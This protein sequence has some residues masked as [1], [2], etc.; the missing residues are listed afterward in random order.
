MVSSIASIEGPFALVLDSI[1]ALLPH[2]PVAE[3]KMALSDS[4]LTVRPLY[5]I[6]RIM[7]ETKPPPVS[8]YLLWFVK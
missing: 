8:R 6:A 2:L 7:P 1:R 5:K 3:G 4:N